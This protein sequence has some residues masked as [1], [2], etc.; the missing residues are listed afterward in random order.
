VA[1]EGYVHI[2]IAPGKTERWSIRYR[3]FARD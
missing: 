3:F 1:P 2:S